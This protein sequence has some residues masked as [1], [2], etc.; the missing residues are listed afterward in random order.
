MTGLEV[1]SITV[2]HT[3]STVETI[4][5][6]KHA[7]E[8]KART[9]GITRL[10]KSPLQRYCG[11]LLHTVANATK[12]RPEAMS[13]RVAQLAVIDTLVS[14][15]AQ[16]PEGLGKESAA[17]HSRSVLEAVLTSSQ[18]TRPAHRVPNPRRASLVRAR[19]ANGTDVPGPNL[20]PSGR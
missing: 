15:C 19:V 11:I 2:S 9:I 12:F 8:V 10:G 20:T 17:H 18:S 6:T 16:R 1:T 7:K 3:G 14:C 13:G 4:T 5:A